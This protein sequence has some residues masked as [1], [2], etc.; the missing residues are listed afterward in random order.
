MT[1]L[2][3][4]GTRYTKTAAERMRKEDL[5]SLVHRYSES[6]QE[7]QS[8]LQ[9]HCE[10]VERLKEQVRLVEG[11]LQ[12]AEAAAQTLERRNAQLLRIEKLAGVMFQMV[13]S[14]K[15]KVALAR[16]LLVAPRE[17]KAA[18]CESCGSIDYSKP[19][20]QPPVTPVE[21]LLDDLESVLL[22]IDTKS[23]LTDN[24]TDAVKRRSDKWRPH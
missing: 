8:I 9:R 20:P 12:K 13:A 19:A 21:A 11:A 24:D 5:A 22:V 4:L 18:T 1:K 17:D 10:E 14:L 6:W 16:R 3:D 15:D 2:S 7:C 23:Q